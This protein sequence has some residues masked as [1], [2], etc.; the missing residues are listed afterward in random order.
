MALHPSARLKMSSQS[1]RDLAIHYADQ[2]SKLADPRR[3]EQLG[4]V[5]GTLEIDG[6]ATCG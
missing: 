3:P 6:V 5:P 1:F 2:G 4:D